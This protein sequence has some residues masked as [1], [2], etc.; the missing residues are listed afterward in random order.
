MLNM[1]TVTYAVCHIKAHHAE[2]CF[3]ESR[4]AECHSAL[5]FAQ[6]F[7]NQVID[8]LLIKYNDTQHNNTVYLTTQST[9]MAQF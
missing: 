1:L 3:A 4:Y 8:K 7:Y 9:K 5:Y 2:C 6:G